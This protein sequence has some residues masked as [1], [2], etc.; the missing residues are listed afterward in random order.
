MMKVLL[1]LVFLYV[2]QA[3]IAT[4]SIR[5]SKFELNMVRKPFMCGNWKMN[6]DLTSA[7]ALATDLVEM[8][9]DVDPNE[10]EIAVCPPFPFLRDVIAVLEKG[11]QKIALV[12]QN[13]FYE[14][15]GAFTGAVSAG[16]LK[17]VGCKYALVGHSE[18][19]AIFN[20]I[21]GDINK[22]V[23]KIQ[24]A[25]VTPILCIGETQLEYE[26]GLN[27]EVCTLQ[28]SKDL[29][30]LTGEQVANTVIAYEPVW[31]IG[32]GLSATPEIAQSVHGAIRAWLTR[33]YGKDV[34]EK[35]IIQYG[36]SVKP[37]TVDELMACPDIDGALV[38]GASL[39][40]ASF[41]RICKFQK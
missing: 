17:S 9:K 16:M 5:R 1:V 26:L 3:W 8:T 28:L 2:A 33:T 31:A 14:D 19:R 6:S 24:E 37:E 41:A 10:R 15:S 21:D 4:P 38:G 18:R 22:V 32:T 25:G 39:D 30:G 13:S 35:V 34:A 7:V 36:G 23:A 40:A 12:A 11:P 29:A 20:E 27:E